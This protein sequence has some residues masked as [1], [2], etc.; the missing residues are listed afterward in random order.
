M[1]KIKALK[2]NLAATYYC[3]GTIIGDGDRKRA[4]FLVMGHREHT[5]LLSR[6]RVN[7]GP[8]RI[9]SLPLSHVV[10]SYTALQGKLLLASPALVRNIVALNSYLGL[11]A[12]CFFDKT[13]VYKPLPRFA[14][15]LT[16]PK[17]LDLR[18]EMKCSELIL[19]AS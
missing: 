4:P 5:V 6:E 2:G 7:K 8:K 17:S 16:R 12:L 9:N 13:N 18:T 1:H 15:F 11:F 3:S 19:E 10:I 14:V